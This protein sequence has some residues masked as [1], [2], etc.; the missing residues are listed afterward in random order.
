MK[1]IVIAS[2]KTGNDER[3]I[4]LLRALFPECEICAVLASPES[5]KEHQND[6]IGI[7]TQSSRR[8]EVQEKN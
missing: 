6:S 5:L 7:S 2:E 1:K 3:L 8:V 4:E